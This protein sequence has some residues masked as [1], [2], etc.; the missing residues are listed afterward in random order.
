MLEIKENNKKNINKEER[1]TNIEILRIIAM[2]MITLHHF[3]LYTGIIYGTEI[4]KKIIYGIFCLVLGK[5]GVG[6]FVLI[7]GYFLIDKKF[8]FKRLFKVWFQVFFYSVELYIVFALLGKTEWMTIKDIIKIFMPITYNQY[9]FMTTYVYLIL[10]T[11][12]INKFVSSL[13]KEQF[14]RVLILLTI[15]LV[16]IPTIIYNNS[17]MSNINTLVTLIVF[18]YLYMIAGYIKKYELSF[19]KGRKVINILI[20]LI[21]Y[22]LAVILEIVTKKL[23]IENPNYEGMFSYYRELNSLPIVLCYISLFYIFKDMKMKNNKFINYIAKISLPVYLI[24]DNNLFR[25]PLWKEIF[26][27]LETD[28]KIKIILTGIIAIIILYLISVIIE[29]FR[30]QL[31]EKPIIKTKLFEKL[32]NKVDEIYNII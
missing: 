32:S 7:T 31:L 20:F 12:L 1:E 29:F 11:P 17:M 2:C 16:I 3:A 13:D 19:L 28:G 25:M 18:A 4:S 23:A 6:I 30:V 8:S 5:I 21:G 22:I 27:I 10:L 9:W 24:Q 26:Y 14:K 15:L